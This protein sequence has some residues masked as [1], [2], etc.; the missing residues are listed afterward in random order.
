MSKNIL[1]G[2]SWGTIMKLTAKSVTSL[3]L[4][5][6]KDRCWF[7]D[8]I[9]G[10]GIRLR[11]GGSST[12]IYR[13][14]VGDQQRSIT[15]GSAAA[16]PFA[17]ARKN[18]GELE[19]KVRLGGD[20]AGEKR[21]I[22]VERENAFGAV[23]RQFIEAKQKE[24]RHKTRSAVT[25]HLFDYAADLHGKPITAVTQRDVALLLNKIAATS[26]DITANRARTTLSALWAWAIRQG[27][28]VTNIAAN[29]EKRKEASRD[30]V[31]SESELAAIWKACGDDDFGRNI[32][33]LILTGQREAEIAQLRW[34][35][36]HD[37]EI[38]LPPSR[39]KNKRTHT[40][41]LTPPALEL[42]GP[43]IHWRTHV[44]GRSDTG[45]K[46]HGNAKARFDKRLDIP[47]WRIHDI[48][49]S[50]ATHM[51]ELGVQ[52][53][54]I[55]AILNHVSGH[56]AGVAGIYNPASYSKEKRDALTMWAE[57]VISLVEG[58]DATVVMQRSA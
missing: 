56:K 4:D 58:R 33:L 20:P 31:L 15:L 13:Y 7:D 22:R 9:S 46:G 50:V 11:E 1:A 54:V 37:D 18:A 41:P 3:S 8:D 27:L 21:A 19:A 12:W 14:R 2:E 48:R 42:I 40:V 30:R 57:H 17:L 6:V 25:R 45:F 34:D 23:A 26:G 55:E 35:E 51:A 5:G 53:H 44:F 29:T 47:A 52:P 16:V 32:K 24:W 39:T 38:I 10:F 28:P 36:V 49:R 43:R